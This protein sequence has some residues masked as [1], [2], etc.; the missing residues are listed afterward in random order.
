MGQKAISFV[1][2]FL[3][4]SLPEL[5][6]KADDLN[7]FKHDVKNYCLNSI[8]NELMKLVSHCYYFKELAI[9]TFSHYVFFCALNTS[10]YFFSISL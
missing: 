5:I 2:P 8:N 9:L 7:T 10:S 4:N 1:D 3:W 6:K